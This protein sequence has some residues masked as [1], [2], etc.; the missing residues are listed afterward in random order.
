MHV[1]TVAAVRSLGMAV[2]FVWHSVCCPSGVGYAD[3]YLE[4]HTEINILCRCM[5]EKRRIYTTSIETS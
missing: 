5:H 1:Y 3:V 2:D 4:L